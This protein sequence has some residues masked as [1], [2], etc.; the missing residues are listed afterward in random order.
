MTNVIDLI[1]ELS[2]FDGDTIHHEDVMKLI[3]DVNNKQYLFTK[4]NFD[5]IMPDWKHY[6]EI[7]IE[8][9]YQR[10]ISCLYISIHSNSNDPEVDKFR[11]TQLEED[12]IYKHGLKD[13]MERL[14]NVNNVD[15][16][17][18]IRGLFHPKL[19]RSFQRRN[20]NL[21]I[22]CLGEGSDS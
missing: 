12:M 10:R 3:N 8:Y 5:E 7:K 20:I 11:D 17:K 22:N 13:M 6:N 9:E 2:R 4:D 1:H 21:V 19:L 15:D 14:L 16:D 18:Y